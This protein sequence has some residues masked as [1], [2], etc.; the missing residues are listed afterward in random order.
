MK[1][2]IWYRERIQRCEKSGCLL[3]LP[4]AKKPCKTSISSFI[5]WEQSILNFKS[6]FPRGGED[7]QDDVR[8]HLTARLLSEG[9]QAK[10]RVWHKPGTPEHQRPLLA[11]SSLVSQTLTATDG[12]E[13]LERGGPRRLGVSCTCQLLSPPHL[14]KANKNDMTAGTSTEANRVTGT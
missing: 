5:K 11:F 7:S 12:A 10:R 8:R 13:S 4:L 3:T 14:P 9:I 1:F 6:A 2:G